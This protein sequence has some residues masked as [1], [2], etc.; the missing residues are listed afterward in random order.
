LSDTQVCDSYIP[1]ASQKI[2][3]AI[4]EG[5]GVIS[6]DGDVS[7]RIDDFNRDPAGAFAVS[8]YLTECIY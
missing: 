8:A 7:F 6:E 3:L 5:G 4:T 2:A 1:V